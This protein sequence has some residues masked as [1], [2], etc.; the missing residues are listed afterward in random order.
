MKAMVDEFQTRTVGPTPNGGSY[1]IAY[2]LDEGQNPVPKKKATYVEII[3]F[4]E[5]GEQVFRTYA[6]CLG[7]NIPDGAVS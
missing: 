2:W 1:A 5:N 6:R 3:E 7:I 4:N